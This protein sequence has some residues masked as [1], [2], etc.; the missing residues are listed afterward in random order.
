MRVGST[1]LALAACGLIGAG[2]EARAG[3]P[4]APG[5]PAPKTGI[6]PGTAK[7]PAAKAKSKTRSTSTRSARLRQA[8][9]QA[10]ARANQ[11][12]MPPASSADPLGLAN[13]LSGGLI[14][15]RLSVIK[16]AAPLNESMPD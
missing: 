11:F 1:L 4:L 2:V 12:I 9:L 7:T 3:D 15:M 13:A 14:P 6:K 5:A 16:N 10:A 8:Q